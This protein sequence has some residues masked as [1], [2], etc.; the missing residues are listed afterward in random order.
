MAWCRRCSESR[1]VEKENEL[2]KEKRLA[3]NFQVSRRYL[4][5]CSQPSSTCAGGKIY[6]LSSPL[7]KNSLSASGVN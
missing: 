7:L 1:R 3:K 2:Q 6:P 5:K 4:C